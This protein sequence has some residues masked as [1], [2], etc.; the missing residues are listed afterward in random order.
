MRDALKAAATQVHNTRPVTCH[1]RLPEVAVQPEKVVW[2]RVFGSGD[3]S[4]WQ[5]NGA[6]GVTWRASSARGGASGRRFYYYYT[7]LLY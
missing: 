7:L 2:T 5:P 3:L 4:V 6:W 1:L